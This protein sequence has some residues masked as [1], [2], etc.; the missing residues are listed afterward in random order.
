VIG[1]PHERADLAGFCGGLQ[2]YLVSMPESIDDSV[3]VSVHDI[4]ETGVHI[5]IAVRFEVD[6]YAQELTC[7]QAILLEA[8]RILPAY[9]LDLRT[10]VQL[11]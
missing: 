3:F 11:P 2:S 4:K 1:P 9:K 5:Q 10:Q 8:V 6:S 7:R